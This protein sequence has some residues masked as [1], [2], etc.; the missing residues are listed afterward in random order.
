MPLTE[1]TVQISEVLDTPV[2]VVAT[3]GV[4]AAVVTAAVPTRFVT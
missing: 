2:V 3:L 1:V 4:A